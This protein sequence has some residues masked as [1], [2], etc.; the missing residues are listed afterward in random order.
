MDEAVANVIM[1]LARYQQNQKEMDDIARRM[2]HISD[3]A[4]GAGAPRQ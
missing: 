2:R 3:Q 4:T 1:L